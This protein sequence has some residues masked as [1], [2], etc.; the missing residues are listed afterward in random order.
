MLPE[1]L[2]KAKCLMSGWPA[3]VRLPGDESMAKPSYSGLER[4]EVYELAIA[5]H[6]QK[7]ELSEWTKC[8]LGL[9]LLMNFAYS[10]VLFFFQSQP[11]V[12]KSHCHEDG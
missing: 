10:L 7:I 5:L 12:R 9:E 6:K 1:T 3:D 8:E 2:A 4:P 11:Q